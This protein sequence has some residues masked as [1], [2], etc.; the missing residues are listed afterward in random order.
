MSDQLPPLPPP[1]TL[2]HYICFIC[3]VGW[4]ASAIAVASHVGTAAPWLDWA[5]ELASQFF[6]GLLAFG[7]FYIQFVAVERFAAGELNFTF[8]HIQVLGGLALF[9]VG[10][11][12]DAAA[13]ILNTPQFGS[14]GLGS[15]LLF[16]ICVLGEGMF[17]ANVVVTYALP[18][19]VAAARP[20]ALVA[21]PAP[22]TRAM[23]ADLQKVAAQFDWSNS[24]AVLFAIAAAFFFVVGVVLVSAVN[25]RVPVLKAGAISYVSPGYLWMPLAI[26][27]AIFAV[28]YWLIEI[29]TGWTF[30]RSATRIHFVCTILAVLESIRI[31]WAWSVTTSNLHF[32]LPAISD[33]F[34]VFA[35]LALATGALVWNVFVGAG[36][37]AQTSRTARPA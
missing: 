30:D 22:Q 1:K 10:I 36:R 31:Y 17:L 35:F 8:G 37:T 18:Q 16:Y 28:I 13:L 26:P 34:G 32:A 11:V 19:G 5:R 4:G 20:A 33:F 6:F 21:R 3:L 9:L 2:L 7:F 27:F 14:N 24:P 29:F 23:P 25:T 15:T 12:R